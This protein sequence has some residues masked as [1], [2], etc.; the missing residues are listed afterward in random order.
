LKGNGKNGRWAFQREH[1]EGIVTYLTKD[2]LTSC[3][4]W[5]RK[6]RWFCGV[7]SVAFAMGMLGIVTAPLV[8]AVDLV[9]I[10]I[11][12]TDSGNA[13]SLVYEISA[14]G[15]FVAFHSDADNLVTSDSNGG[16]DV[17][18]RDLQS[19]TTTLVSVNN[20]GTDSGNGS[21]RY[22]A[23]SAEG[24]FVTFYSDADDL[25]AM[26]S[27]GERDVFVSDLQSGITTLVSVNKDGT[28]SGN[29]S[30]RNSAISADGRFVTFYSNADDLVAMDTNGTWDVFVRDLHSGI[31]SLVS[32][33][34]D[35]TDSGNDS[36]WY[37]EISADGRFVAFTSRADDLVA[38]DTNGTSDVFVRDL[39]SGTTSLVSVNNDTTDSGN[40]ISSK[41]MLSA[42]GR[43]LA[44]VSLANDLVATDNNSMSDVFVRD[45]Q[46][47]TTSLV[48][49]NNDATDSGAGNSG[50][51]GYTVISADGHFVAF[52][53]VA[54]DLVDTD[55]NGAWDIFVRDLQSGT[56]T[57]VSVNRD[58]TNS[59]TGNSKFPVISADGR[60]VAFTSLAEDLVPTDTNSASDVFV[61]DLQSETT[62]LVSINRDG[63]NSATG[64]SKVPVI[65]ADGRFVA[66]GSLADDLVARDTNSTWDI[67]AY[68][69]FAAPQGCN[70]DDPKAIKGTSDPDFLYGTEQADIICGLGGQDFIA[71]LDGD[72]CIDG[73]DGN[74]WIYGGR[75]DERI[76][77]RTGQDIIYG[78]R[79]NDEI[80]GGDDNDFLFG[81][82]GDDRLDGGEGY[83][84]LFCGQG[85]D[86]GIGEYVRGC[87]N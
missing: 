55:T 13:S 43:F 56:T 60:F 20:D 23:I 25:V 53:S 17:F 33:N 64:D 24:R 52:N 8:S 16:R 19:G 47:G 86:E 35:A 50:D 12:G 71:G 74:D 22:S 40:G 5:V 14:D 78:H 80:S 1:K 79:G 70:C 63:T 11:E 62:T 42:D 61:R 2:S 82:V 45:L 37:P 68:E 15:R 48:S 34:N 69:V 21:S 75:G 36:S 44:F 85:T 39:K 9:S 84:W 87:E 51:M 49:V 18:V 77:G 28:D 3:F 58:G 26:D 41:P 81:G 6:W 7:Q 73:G 76:F 59:A 31:T 10:N 4:R 83:D 57:L 38:T 67:F 54:D 27:N 30:S 46:S 29:G 66:F 65:S 32:V 72:D